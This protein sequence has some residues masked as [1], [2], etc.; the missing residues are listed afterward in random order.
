MP[1]TIALWIERRRF[2]RLRVRDGAVSFLEG[3]NM[4]TGRLLDIGLGGVGFKYAGAGNGDGTYAGRTGETHVFVNSDLFLLTQVAG[5]VVSDHAIGARAVMASRT[6]GRCGVCFQALPHSKTEYL[7]QYLGMQSRQRRTANMLEKELD[8][9]EERYRSIVEGIGEGYVETD[10]LGHMI[11]FN[12]AMTVLTGFPRQELTGRNIRRLMTRETRSR[13]FQLYRKAE[14]RNTPIPVVDWEIIGKDGASRTV[15]AATTF[16]RAADNRIT[17]FRVV[18]RDVG[19]RRER[20]KALL[21]RASHDSLTG[22]YNRDAFGVCLAD[23][24]G[25]TRRTGHRMGLLFLDLD[26]FKEANDQFGHD[27]GDDLIR[28]VARRL[29][30]TLRESDV[31]SRYGGDEFTVI[32]NGG[33]YLDPETVAEKLLD[34][35]SAPYHINGHTIDFLTASIGISLFPEDGIDPDALVRQA[36]QAMYRAKQTRNQYARCEAVVV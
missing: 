29:T 36:D 27:T 4:R 31:V 7:D 26:R 8:I 9:R 22:L 25:R 18:L 20:E 33:E 2:P 32:L 13:V 5:Q 15:E 24:I 16:I 21:Y 28:E 10:I 19:T 35:I 34:R 1:E 6:M 11:F 12:R 14:Q 30:D 3:E 17:G 23:I